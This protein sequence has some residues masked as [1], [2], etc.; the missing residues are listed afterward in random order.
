MALLK[1]DE[2]YLISRGF[3]YK[4][5]E[6]NN[7]LF[8]VLKDYK[9]STEYNQHQ[10]DV[11]IRIPIGYPMVGIDM[12][13]VKPYIK[14]AATNMNPPATDGIASFIGTD[15]QQFSRHYPWKPTYNLET[16]IKMIDDVL[17][18]GRW[19]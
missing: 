14:I 13:F 8:L 15:W 9:L 4:V 2:D 16:H 5:S 3:T 7:G 11:L 17:A 12:F 6:D 10:T 19:Q 1:H 18:R